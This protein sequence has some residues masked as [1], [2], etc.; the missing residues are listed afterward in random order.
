MFIHNTWQRSLTS[1]GARDC[2]WEVMLE[3]RSERGTVVSEPKSLGAGG[4]C[5]CVYARVRA[6]P[7]VVEMRGGEGTPGSA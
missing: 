3:L 2:L 7:Q 1:P 5:V 4:W 6:F